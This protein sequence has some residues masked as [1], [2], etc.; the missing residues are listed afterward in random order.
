MKKFLIAVIVLAAIG[1]AVFYLMPSGKDETK[2]LTSAGAGA[3]KTVE[4]V[5]TTS[6]DRVFVLG[7]DNTTIG[8]TCA[9]TVA[10]KIITVQGGWR[11]SLD[12][13][14]AGEALVGVDN[15]LRSVK[16]E[17][18][19]GSVWSEQPMLTTALTKWGFFQVAEHP[20]ATFVTTAIKP[21]A[22][23]SAGFSNATHTLEGNFKLNGIEK[24]IAI[25]AVI[26]VAGDQL[27][28]QS[29]FSLNRKEFNCGL[30]DVSMVLLTDDDIAKDVALK[31]K[32]DARIGG[33]AAGATATAAAGATAAQAEVK[34]LTEAEIAALPKEYKETIPVSQISFEMVLV[35]GDPA[36][37]TA[38]YFIGK[39]EVTW[40]EYMPWMTCEDV[41]DKEEHGL[42][43]AMKVRPSMSY[44]DVT[45]GYG[46]SGFPALSMSR[47]SAELYCKWLSE[48]TGRRY[49]LPTETEWK[50]AW[51]LGGGAAEA[52]ASDEAADKDA[53]FLFNAF[54]DFDGKEKPRKAGS[55]APNTLGLYDMAGNVA[56]WAVTPGSTNRFVLGGHYKGTYDQ[57][58]AACRLDEHFDWN[59]NYPNEPKSIWWFVDAEWTGIRLVC[60]PA[61]GFKAP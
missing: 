11:G 21:G 49:R 36:T 30:V 16:L 20:K 34:P 32:V 42:L 26:E 48:Q 15:A 1:V 56:E 18:E 55:K 31:V 3:A 33:A 13:K 4:V 57:L 46:T 38:P 60:E 52:Y 51:T 27:K 58:G 41:P 59:L 5:Q 45:R 17:I 61:S 28:I 54:D 19:A 7:A 47:F 37:K 8:F 25:P 12:G 9:K 6:G 23:D 35:P 29:A 2:G 24:S 39:K 14:L 44:I 43:R 10:G 50:R 22:P 53:I 40:D